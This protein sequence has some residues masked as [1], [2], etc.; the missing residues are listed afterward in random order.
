[1]P[2]TDFRDTTKPPRAVAA[3]A[4]RTAAL[5]GGGEVEIEQAMNGVLQIL[6]IRPLQ[7]T[8]FCSR[9]AAAAN[10]VRINQNDASAQVSLDRL[11]LLCGR[12]RGQKEDVLLKTEPLGQPMECPMPQLNDLS[13]SLAALEQ[14][15]TLIAAIE[16]GQSN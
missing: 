11:L 2:C 13:R 1:M 5:A 8:A 15:T 7:P 6:G 9:S 4:V 10:A 14:D 12:R 3:N 16:M